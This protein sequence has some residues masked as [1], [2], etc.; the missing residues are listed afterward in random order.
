MV[1]RNINQNLNGY[2][3]PLLAILKS[4]GPPLRHSETKN[5]GIV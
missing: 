2:E 5:S 1:D 4:F 3:A